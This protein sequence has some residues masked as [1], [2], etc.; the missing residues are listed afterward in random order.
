MMNIKN[1]VA[2][3]GCLAITMLVFNAKSQT[4]ASLFEGIIVGG[5]VDHGAFVNC[6][7]PCIKFNKK[8]YSLLLGLLPSLRIKKDKVPEG[9]PQNSVF[10]PNLG[11]GLTATMHHLALQVPLYY[12]NKTAL[13]DGK[14]NAG[15]GVGYKF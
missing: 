6:T 1:F 3:I 14:W 5:Y 4:K 11:V 10:T 8:P 2:I 9:A 15:I 7:G 13:K 12:N